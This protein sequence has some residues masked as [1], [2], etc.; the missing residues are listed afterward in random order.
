MVDPGT[1]MLVSAGI[2]AG[3]S[4]LGGIFGGNASRDAARYNYA[5]NERNI[6]SQERENML[7]RMMAERLLGIQLEGGQ[8]AMGNTSRYEPGR[9]I[10]T[11]L[12]DQ[13]KQIQSGQVRALL[14][15]LTGDEALRTEDR[16]RSASS[17]RDDQSQADSYRDRLRRSGA[18]VPRTNDLFNLFQARGSAA[19][20]Q[21]QDRA[22][23][24]VLTQNLRRGGSDGSA[25][26]ILAQFASE[27]AA[28]RSDQAVENQL[29]TLDLPGQLRD[30]KEGRA[31][32]LLNVFQARANNA[33]QVPLLPDT[34]SPQANQLAQGAR[35]GVSGVSPAAIFASGGQAA[36]GQF[37]PADMS[38][39]NMFTALGNAGSGL[40]DAFV[41]RSLFDE[42]R[43][44][45]EAY[46]RY[47]GNQSSG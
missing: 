25:A 15:R 9:G 2:G 40:M 12:S 21:S 42:Q 22:L 37:M 8:D 10:V 45:N 18:N 14:E 17:R 47:L 13:S 23:D 26:K 4:V 19:Y 30:A 29:R 28:H 33:P 20:N 39:A 1:A 46:R 7:R 41:S 38:T 43:Q 44:N 11:N 6:Q 35:A 27:G 36:Q 3:G 16:D 24:R 34:A 5:M 32:N 31:A